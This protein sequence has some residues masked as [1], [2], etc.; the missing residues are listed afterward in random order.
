M[1]LLLPWVRRV[2]TNYT[3][4]QKGGKLTSKQSIDGPFLWGSSIGLLKWWVHTN[5][6][7]NEQKDLKSNSPT[8]Y[9]HYAIMFSSSCP[10]QKCVAVISTIIIMIISNI[11]VAHTWSHIYIILHRGKLFPNT[12]NLK[13]TFQ[14]GFLIF[15]F[16]HIIFFDKLFQ[17]LRTLVELH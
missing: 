9:L 3:N 8:I 1:A 11:L 17:N 13:S 12:N 4:E 7:K 2:Q 10:T 14:R 16:C 6:F 15:Q 5:N